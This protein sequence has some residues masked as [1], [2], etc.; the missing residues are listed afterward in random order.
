[1][2]A[3]TACTITGHHFVDGLEVTTD[4]AADVIADVIV[5]NEG[6]ITCTI[7]VGAPLSHD[8]TVTNPD[9]QHCTIE[10]AFTA[11]F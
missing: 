1:M 10:D 5:V 11:G 6:T 9:S 2:D 3:P 7:T 4:P 8:V